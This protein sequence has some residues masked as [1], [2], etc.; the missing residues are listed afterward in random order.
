MDEVYTHKEWFI[1]TPY[2]VDLYDGYCLQFKE[3][4]DY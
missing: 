4:I 2:L 1:Y 3:R